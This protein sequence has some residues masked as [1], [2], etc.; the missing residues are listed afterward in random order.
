MRTK[1]HTLSPEL[2]LCTSYEYGT[3]FQTG[4][5][6]RFRFIHNTE[7]APNLGS[8]FGQDIEPHGRYIL[9]NPNPGDL[10]RKWEAG[11]T[12][13]QK[14]LV[15]RMVASGSDDY[16]GPQGWKARLS[17]VFGGRKGKWLTCHL[18]KLG[19]DGIVTCDGDAYT[20]EIVDLRPVRCRS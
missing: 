9:H 1:A 6:V 16:Y 3:T 5:P 18:R 15:L 7:K 8:K 12:E 13:F 2:G 14:P 17:R 11:E 4:R 10:P 19:Y 20:R